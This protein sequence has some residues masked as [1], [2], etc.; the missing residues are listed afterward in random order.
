MI[1]RVEQWGTSLAVRIPETFASQVGLTDNGL[2]EIEVVEGRL[3]IRTPIRV[4]PKLEELLRGITP[5][6]CHGEWETGPT[7]G[8]EV[9]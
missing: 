2:V 9:W 5:E 4:I 3:V 6:N 8:D 7:V 1:T